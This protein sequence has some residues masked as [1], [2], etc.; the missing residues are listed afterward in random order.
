MV[1]GRTGLIRLLIGV[2]RKGLMH[3]CTDQS[4]C[5]HATAMWLYV[6]SEQSPTEQ[7]RDYP[8]LG[9]NANRLLKVSFE[10]CKCIACWT[11]SSE[12]AVA[13]GPL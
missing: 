10:G 6:R 9:P 13:F 3:F 7:A 4:V 2:S 5:S 1:R 8:R 11:A 12:A